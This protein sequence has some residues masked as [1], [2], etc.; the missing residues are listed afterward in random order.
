MLGRCSDTSTTEHSRPAA[1]LRRIGRLTSG[2]DALAFVQEVA[3]MPLGDPTPWM[4]S[5]AME[6]LARAERLHRQGFP[7]GRASGRPVWE[8][9]VDMLETDEQVLI[10]VALPGV[11]AEDAEAAIEGGDLVISGRR[12]LPPQLRTAFIHRLELPQGC[13]ERRVRL[14]P[15]RYDRLAR[16]V[17][18]GCL[19]INLHKA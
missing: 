13:F 3:A 1:R 10:I 19:L 12:A 17:S 14:P 15:G 8:P 16:T 18:D 6:M 11:R 5:E 9:P 2:D 7:P 4:W